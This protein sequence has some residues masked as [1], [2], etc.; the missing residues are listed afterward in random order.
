MTDSEFV[1]TVAR[2]CAAADTLAG[3]KDPEARWPY[4]TVLA[5]MIVQGLHK[6]GIYAKESGQ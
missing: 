3:D 5:A 1:E 2:A 6:R 4:Y